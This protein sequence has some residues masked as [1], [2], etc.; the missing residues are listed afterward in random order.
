MEDRIAR[1]T[2]METRL[3]RLHSWLKLQDHDITE[4]VRVLAEYYQSLWRAGFE[5]DEVGLL[6]DNL[7]RGVLSE[8]ALYNALSD[9]EERINTLFQYEG[10]LVRITDSLGRS[11]TGTADTFPCGYGE[12]AYGREEEGIQIGEYVIFKSDIAGITV[13]PTYEEAV[14]TI[15]PGRYRHFK[16]KEYEVIGIARNSETEEPMVVYRALYDNGSLW[17]RPASM[18]NET[19][20]RDGRTYRRF[21]RIK[22]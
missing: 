17:A 10:K 12:H 2:E 22:G 6:P 13:L 20:V 14:D 15:L 11:F 7:P 8:D 3:N 4:D 1:V 21:E 5:A 18:W 19:V 16:G 9:Y